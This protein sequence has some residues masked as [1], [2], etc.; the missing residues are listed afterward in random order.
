MRGMLAEECSRGA[1]PG[2]ILTVENTLITVGIHNTD[3][4]I[5]CYSEEG[6]EWVWQPEGTLLEILEVLDRRSAEIRR[7]GFQA[8][9]G[10][11]VFASR[12][13]GYTP[14]TLFSSDSSPGCL[15]WKSEAY[16]MIHAWELLDCRLRVVSVP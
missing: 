11:R 14:G 13:I 16:R 8:E 10:L 7:E 2:E 15:A 9:P 6:K 1:R 3:R 5:G 12:E 4:V